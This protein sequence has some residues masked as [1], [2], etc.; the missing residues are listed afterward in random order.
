MYVSL[1]VKK[2]DFLAHNEA[3]LE[4]WLGTVVIDLKGQFP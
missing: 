2:A 3:V 1:R 4:V